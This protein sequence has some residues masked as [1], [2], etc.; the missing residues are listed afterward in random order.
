MSSRFNATQGRSSGVQINAIT[1]SGTNTFSGSFAGYFRHD[2][3]NA[4]DFI[5]QE[6]LPLDNKQFSG[7]FGG[8][9]LEDRIHFFG[10]FERETEPRTAVWNTA[11]PHFNL[12]LS[13]SFVDKKGGGRVDAQFTPRIRVTGRTTHWR[14]SDPFAAS[15][16][17]NSGSPS[18][19]GGNTWTTD[20]VMG[21]LTQVLSNRAVN[22]IKVGYSYIFFDEYAGKFGEIF[23]PAVDLA[24]FDAGAGSDAQF[25]GNTIYNIRDDFTYSV[26]RHTI[27]LGGEYLNQEVTDARCSN[28]QG[29]LDATGGPIPDND[30]LA[31]LFPDLFDPSTWNLAPLSPLAVRFDQQFFTSNTSL[32]PRDI[33]GFWA[34]DDWDV[35]DRLTL[36]VGLRYDYERNAYANDFAVLPFVQ[37]GRPDDTDNFAPRLGFT[38]SANEQTVVRGGFGL[39]FTTVTNPHQ[40]VFQGS[41]ID[42]RVENDGR[43]DFASNPFNGPAPTFA[44]L[45]TQVCTPEAPTEPGCKRRQLVSSG[46]LNAHAPGYE[47]PLSYQTSIGL[48]RQLSPTMAVEADY[49][50][51]GF[52]GLPENQNINLTYDA[53][54][55]LNNPFS[56]IS[57]RPFPDWAYVNLTFNQ[58]RYNDHSLQTAWTKRMSEGWQASATYRLGGLWESSGPIHSG[59]DVVT[60]P[61]AEDLGEQDSLSVGDQR[62][63]AVFNGIWQLPY[64]FQVSGLYFFGSGERLG[65]FWGQDLRDYGSSRRGERRLR[66]DGTIIP[67]NDFVGKALHR[68]DLRFQRR[69]LL[70]GGAGDRRD[71]GGLQPVQPRELRTL[72]NQRKVLYLFAAAAAARHQ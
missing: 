28:C 71:R 70:G 6:V 14:A 47:M 63:R 49:V 62:H 5:A 66:P 55:G 46:I 45:L 8:P 18:K 31:S 20:Q 43:P 57:R 60:F 16:G 36:N 3:L 44:E 22:E 51:L 2:S 72:P 59:F 1:K 58:H 39:Y 27:K 13:S 29:V 56:D 38:F 7:T 26:G 52:R 30:T 10:Y 9:L 50:Y 69:F 34:Q 40:L 11:F 33:F 23:A 19:G 17:S 25:Q 65:T 37:S 32:I 48:Q 61:L 54:T 53:A 35:M 42:T 15:G 64:D 21:T 68:V 24:G 4:A 12:N 67:R 41:I